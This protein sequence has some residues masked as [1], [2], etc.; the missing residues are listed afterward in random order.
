MKKIGEFICNNKKFIL[1]LTL[2]LVILSFVGMKMTKINYDILVYLPE[3]IDTVK[4]QNI[5]ADDF[6]LGAFSITL[7]D[8]MSKADILKLEDKIRNVDGVVKVISAYDVVGD[9]IPLDMLPSDVVSRFNNGKTDIMLITYDETTSSQ[10]TLDAVNAVKEITQNSCKVGGMSS[11]VLDTMELSETE[12]IIYIVIA[13]ILCIVILEL[14]LD[15]YII[16]LLLLINIG[17]SILFNMGSNIIFGNISY[18]TKALVAVLQLGVTTDFSI[19]L[20]HSYEKNRD[21]YASKEE[22]MVNAI[23]ET[24]TSVMG[25]SLTTIAGFLVLCTMKL[26][27]GSDLGLVMAKGVLLGVICVLTVFPV[28]LL[29]FDKYIDKTKHK[30]ILPN[31][32]YLNNFVIKFY[33]VIFGIFIVLFIPVYLANNKIDIYYK[34][35]DTLPKYL[36]SIV[37]NEE[38]KDKF[39]IVSPE[40]ILIDKDIKANDI[41]DMVN[42]IETIDGVDFVISFSKLA[43]M[44]ITPDMLSEDIVNFFESDKYQMILLNSTYE[45]ASLELNSQVEVIEDIVKKYDDEALVAG[46]GP[47]MK[48]LVK[49]SDTDFNSVNTSSIIC[50][51]MIMFFVLRSISLPILLIGVIEFAIFVNMSIPYFSGISLPFVAPIVLGTIQLGATIDYAILMTTTY[52]K[53]RK[54]YKNK[55]D[56]MKVTMDSCVSSIVVSGLCFFGATFG[57]GIYSELEMISSLCTLISRGAIISMVVVI[58]VLPSILLIFDK[59]ICKTTLSF[60]KGD[61]MKKNFKKVCVWALII[62]VCMSNVPVYALSKDETV[63]AKLNNDGSVKS[64]KV[65]DHLINDLNLNEI[66]DITDL[67]DIENVNG[68]EKFKIVNNS[69]Q[70]EANG[71]DIFYQGV[72]KNDIP[73]SVNIKYYLDGKEKKLDYILGKSGKVDIK[74]KYLNNSKKYVKVNGREQ[75]LYT[76]FVVTSATVIDSKNN[77]NIEINNGKVVSNGT[78]NVVVGISVPG[79]FDSLKID[80]LKDMDEVTISYDTTKFELASIYMVITPKVIDSDDLKILD[81]MDS[82]YDSMDTLK[83]SIDSI[84]DGSKDIVEAMSKISNGNSQIADNLNMVATKLE[85]LENGTINLRDGLRDIINNLSQ[86]K[87]MILNSDNSNSIS[88]IQY[89]ISQNN[90][91]IEK[92]N[93]TNSTLKNNY[94]TYNLANLSVNDIMLFNSQVYSNFG[95]SLSDEEVMDMNIKLINVKSTYESSYEANNNLITLLSGDNQALESSLA[96]MEEVS[97]QISSLINTLYGYLTKVENGANELSNGTSQIKDGVK[98]LAEKTSELS[99]GSKSLYD[100]TLKLSRGINTFN[101]SGITKLNNYVNGDVKSMQGKIEALVKLGEEYDTFTMKE[102]NVN[103]NVK[104]ILVMDSVKVKEDK[105]EIINTDKKESFWTKFKN[106]FK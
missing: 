83:G 63:Y 90:A 78:S 91:T 81:D 36:D 44:G 66:D 41:N 53:N 37:A 48:D 87:E 52:L 54:I 72:S 84:E 24:F 45:I 56:A 95:L 89:L 97:N 8:N 59:V 46:E 65:V 105:K 6:D 16:P 9:T 58:M 93:T 5:L 10:K 98:L 49:I 35:D 27:L 33:K 60:R 17:I 57:V 64:V 22:A 75:L 21:K 70:W 62:G 1:I 2:I 13:V 86:A 92:L 28:L 34:L 23:S 20:Y 15:S 82:F 32:S 103:G 80:S 25:S 67:S 79:M 88:Q 102:D 73:V 7:I 29:T 26:T 69:L 101:E 31:F 68:N 40:I 55:S 104:M 96:T 74:I 30:K 51:F 76:P 106:L 71:N 14:S 100:G 4:G 94:D 39:N 19:F 12:I 43:S 50:I 11:M 85:E 99:S 47:L 3:D 77:S 38:L 18:I 42:E 61:V